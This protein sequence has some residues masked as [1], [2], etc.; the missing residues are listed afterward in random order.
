MQVNFD[1]LVAQSEAA[2]R[3]Q[4]ERLARQRAVLRQ[5]V[6]EIKQEMRGVL[7][8]GNIVLRH[9]YLYFSSHESR[10]QRS[11]QLTFRMRNI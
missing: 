9:G 2:R 5:K 1:E 8:G 4:E 7:E 10:W 6:Q 3:R 11:V